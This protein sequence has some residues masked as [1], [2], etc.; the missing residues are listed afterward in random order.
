MHWV[1]S[2]DRSAVLKI[3]VE[4]RVAPYNTRQQEA[5]VQTVA[6]DAGLAAGVIHADRHIYLTEYVEGTVWSAATFTAG[7]GPFALS[8]QV[9]VNPATPSGTAI[10]NVAT[11]ES[12]ETQLF[13]S[14][15]VSTTVSGVRDMLSIP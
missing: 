13:S 8:F 5:A 12:N 9:R 14:N 6:A 10:D 2:T 1:P 4:P 7:T 3:D 11:Y 15:Q